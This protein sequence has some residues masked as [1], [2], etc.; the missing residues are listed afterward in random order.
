MDETKDG[1]KKAKFRARYFF[2]AYVI[3]VGTATLLWNAQEGHLIEWYAENGA[4]IGKLRVAR[5]FR[6]FLALYSI[7]VQPICWVLTPL[8]LW[9]AAFREKS[10]WARLSCVLEALVCAYFFYRFLVLGVV[11]F[12]F[13]SS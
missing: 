6:D 9:Q 8:F 12:T 3:A 13:N 7:W 1:T 4:R 11:E 5:D 2:L 10:P